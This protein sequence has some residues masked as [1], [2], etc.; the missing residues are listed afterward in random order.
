EARDGRGGML[1][2]SAIAST[3]KCVV[4][5]LVNVSKRRRARRRAESTSPGAS[6]RDGG[7]ASRSEVNASILA[8][9]R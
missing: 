1:R 9:G 6:A 2:L 3:F 4:R 7:R 8:R 5:D